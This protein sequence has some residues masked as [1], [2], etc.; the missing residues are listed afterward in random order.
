MCWN[1]A[2]TMI[3]SVVSAWHIE[4]ERLARQGKGVWTLQN[5]NL[6]AQAQHLNA[7]VAVFQVDGGGAS[8]ALPSPAR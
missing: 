8:L 3:G 1:I 4:K 6:Q 5:D 2:S 7:L